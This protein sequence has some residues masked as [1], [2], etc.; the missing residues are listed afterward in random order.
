MGAVAVK[1]I[2][3]CKRCIGGQVAE[4][5]CLQCG[6]EHNEQGNLVKARVDPRVNPMLVPHLNY[7]PLGVSYPENR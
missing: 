3:P 1:S 5:K 7:C 2:M 4:G 6:A